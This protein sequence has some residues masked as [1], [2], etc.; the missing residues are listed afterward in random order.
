MGALG[1]PRPGCGPAG[2]R[3]PMWRLQQAGWCWNTA[4][5]A[6]LPMSCPPALQWQC[7]RVGDPGE[8][9][10]VRPPRCRGWPSVS[11]ALGDLGTTAPTGVG[12]PS[13]EG[14]G[15]GAETAK[16]TSAGGGFTPRQGS[17]GPSPDT[18]GSGV[19]AAGDARETAREGEAL[20]VAPEWWPGA[21]GPPQDSR[22]SLG[23]GHVQQRR[24][25]GSHVLGA[26]L[27]RSRGHVGFLVE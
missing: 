15:T 5:R 14:Q 25:D 3:G 18:A 21:G 11:T 22:R 7:R 12:G 1:V 24:R 16:V 26:N 10:T 13:P 4:P 17:A 19:Q 23:Q 2:E 9:T 6:P 20:A 27:K 8:G